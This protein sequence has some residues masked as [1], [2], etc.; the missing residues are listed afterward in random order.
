MLVLKA[1]FGEEIRRVTL[2]KD[3]ESFRELIGII[4][5][6]VKNFH[7]H[8]YQIKYV[9]EEQELITIS[10]DNDVKEALL[11]VSK[12]SDKVLRV[13]FK[14]IPKPV[15]TR[16]TQT[17]SKKDYVRQASDFVDGLVR[18]FEKIEIVEQIH[19]FFEKLFE[20]KQDQSPQHIHLAPPEEV[21][22][23]LETIAVPPPSIEASE[24]EI[25]EK[26][27]SEPPKEELH[28]DLPPLVEE[29]VVEKVPL[30]S[31]VIVN[32]VPP[33]Q[34]SK[35]VE[36]LLEMG[37]TDPVLLQE[38]LDANKNDVELTIVQLLNFVHL[39]HE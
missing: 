21:P 9:D 33:V 29:I 2:E 7:R 32:E 38:L 12:K 3:P 11:V 16:E 35:E 20:A 31:S 24:P 28:E 1:Y 39:K 30:S 19:R 6:L 27:S 34:C 14:E 8:S 18:D 22:E 10:N 15:E 5:R 17:V 13:Y 23:L 36:Q 4:K 37:F 26:P 25:E